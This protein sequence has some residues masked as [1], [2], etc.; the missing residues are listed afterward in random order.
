MRTFYLQTPL[1]AESTP[2]HIWLEDSPAYG[3]YLAVHS[4]S[5]ASTN[6]QLFYVTDFDDLTPYYQEQLA[7]L[8]RMQRLIVA[9]LSAADRPLA[10]KEL[11]ERIGYDQRSTAKA[12]SDLNERA[13][14]KPVSTIFCRLT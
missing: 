6:S 9:E 3:H 2:S 1:P 14:L 10:V 7:R 5:K 4:R 12:V 11:A 13:W 8:S